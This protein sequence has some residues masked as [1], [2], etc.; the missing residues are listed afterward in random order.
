MNEIKP[1]NR[2]VVETPRLLLRPI[3]LADL[4][5]M[6]ENWA[7]DDEVTKYLSWE[8]HK[9]IEDTRRVITSWLLMYEKPYFFQ[10]AITIKKT[11]EVIGTISFFDLKFDLLQAEIGYC[12]GR[13]FWNRGYGT[14]ALQGVI[15]YAFSQN[16]FQILIANHLIENP[17]SGRVMEKCR[18]KY[19]GDF[20]KPNCKSHQSGILKSYQITKTMWG[21]TAEKQ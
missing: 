13:A 12:L 18:M 17:A 1:F 4:K 11:G 5:Q 9:S 2:T 19:D 20:F 14:E 7:S 8:T 21:K 3:S 10:W 15:D 16:N 6:Y